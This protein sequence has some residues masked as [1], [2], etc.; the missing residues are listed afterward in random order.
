MAVTTNE[1][2]L[3]ANLTAALREASMYSEEQSAVFASLRR[4]TARLDG[5]A[6]PCAVAGGVALFAHG[7]RRFT[8]RVCAR[9]AWTGSGMLATHVGPL[10]RL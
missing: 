4:V 5:R 10:R 8:G 2:R 3:S 7:F 9:C 1:S 6:I